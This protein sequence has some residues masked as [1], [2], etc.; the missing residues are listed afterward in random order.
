[1]ELFGSVSRYYQLNFA[2]NKNSLYWDAPTVIVSHSQLCSLW[3]PE[4]E[5]LF[6]LLFQNLNPL[7]DLEVLSNCKNTICANLYLSE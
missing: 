4:A 7:E 1:M 3:W 5:L 6:L 2:T